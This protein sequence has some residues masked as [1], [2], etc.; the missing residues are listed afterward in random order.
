MKILIWSGY[1]NPRWDKK[2]WINKGIGGTEYC[3]IKLADYLDLK[4]HDVTVTGDVNEG[5]FWG[6]K[7]IHYGNFHR[8]QGPIGTTNPHSLQVYPHYDVVISTNY[9]HFTKHLE[10]YNI[11]FDKAYFWMHNEYFYKWY[12]GNELKNWSSYLQDNRLKGI[13]GVSK[14]HEEYLTEHK[15]E[16][17]N[18]SD[19][20]HPPIL[21]IDNA[22]DL[23]DYNNVPPQDKIKGRIIWS[24]SPDRGLDL[25]L[26]N[27]NKW[28]E[29]RP[30]LSLVICSPPYS[31]KWFNH[32][33]SQLKDVMWLGALNPSDL[34]IEQ[35]RAE[36][37]V[38][39]SDYLETYCITALE[40]M[41]AGVKILTNGAGNIKHLI[42]KGSRGELIEINPDTIIETLLKDVE[43]EE[44]HR[45]WIWKTNEAWSWARKQN[46]ENRVN[47]WISLMQG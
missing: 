35:L 25:I 39:A 12:R 17:F 41:M 31:S 43:D 38:Y 18:Y 13:V 11:K 28:K 23:N 32:D 37:W 7:Y 24:S 26:S 46:W 3:V 4:G 10:D 19:E 20:Q 42:N 22:I 45:N 40:M 27:W 29:L 34:K 5:N 15:T 9:I 2:D 16:L 14:F 21:S 6:V 36:Y 44:F 1:H 8:Y 33:V 47:E 30:D